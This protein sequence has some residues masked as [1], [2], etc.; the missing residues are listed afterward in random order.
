MLSDAEAL[1]SNVAVMAKG[2]LAVS[3]RLADLLAN[4]TRAW[5]L[6]VSGAS[7][8]VIDRIAPRLT[9]V[10]PLGGGRY[11]LELPATTPPEPLLNE[12]V[13]TGA[14]LVSLNPV[15]ETL[16]EFFVQR[17]NATNA[18][19]FVESRVRDRSAS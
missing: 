18:D 2:R 9:S 17:V 5:E 10:T 14:R 7:Q 11:S 13:T 6:V 12:L 8:H 16:E 15:R 4:Q 19:R 3:G 1:C